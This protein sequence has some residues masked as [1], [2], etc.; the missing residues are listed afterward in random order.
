MAHMFI[1]VIDGSGVFALCMAIIGI[2]VGFIIDATSKHL[3]RHLEHE[4]Q[5]AAYTAL[6]GS[7]PPPPPC[8]NEQPPYNEHVSRHKTAIT[9]IANSILSAIIALYFGLGWSAFMVL[10]LTWG[11]FTLSLIDAEH[12]LLPDILVLPMLWIGLLVNSFHLF[13]SPENAL[14]GAVVG[15]LAL[16]SALWVSKIITGEEGIGRGDL[17][18]LAMLGAWGGWQVLPLTILLASLG[19]VLV[20]FILIGLKKTKR[21]DPLPFGPYLAVGGWIAFLVIPRG[22]FFS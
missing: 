13:A 1:T 18:L 4:C 17:K 16:W 9:V 21:S 15:Y 22:L 14:W 19:G 10:I 3:P 11:L 2:P 8:R 12:L 7:G 5:V 6:G 20:S